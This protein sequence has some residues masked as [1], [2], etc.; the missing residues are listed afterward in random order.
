[1]AI[2]PVNLKSLAR[3]HTETAIRVLSKCMSCKDA[4]W[5]TRIT[6]ATILLDRGYGR[7]AT[8]IQGD[9]DG[10]P[11]KVTYSREELARRVATLFDA[12]SRARDITPELTEGDIPQVID[13]IDLSESD[14]STS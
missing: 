13:I 3:S 14:D 11:V 1:M 7:P 5:S 10:G 2:K 8:I 4:P 12:A 9:E 6:A